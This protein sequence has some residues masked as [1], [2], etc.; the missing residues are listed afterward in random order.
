VVREGCFIV[1][2]TFISGSKRRVEHVT[3]TEEESKAQSAFVGKSE[4]VLL[5]DLGVWRSLM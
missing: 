2:M 5:E 3:G 4:D 1:A